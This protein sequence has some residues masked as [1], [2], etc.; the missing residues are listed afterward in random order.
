MSKHK[1]NSSFFSQRNAYCKR[2]RV[3]CSYSP[4][5]CEGSRILRFGIFNG[6]AIVRPVG[7]LDRKGGA[8]QVAAEDSRGLVDDLWRISHDGGTFTQTTRGT[9]QFHAF[10]MRIRSE[11]GG[12][13]CVD[14]LKDSIRNTLVI[15]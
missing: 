5:D 7:A 4:Q 12:K 6:F 11:R 3:D 1:D 10:Q 15:T 2:T 14:N 8:S 9:S 13:L